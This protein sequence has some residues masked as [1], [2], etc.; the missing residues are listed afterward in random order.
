[1]DLW[2]DTM[3]G[4]T[5]LGVTSRIGESVAEHINKAV[6]RKQPRGVVAL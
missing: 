2:R 1:M 4:E 6:R 5:K 3:A